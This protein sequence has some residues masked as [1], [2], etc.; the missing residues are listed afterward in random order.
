M[1]N[2][3]IIIL[4]TFVAIFVIFVVTVAVCSAQTSAQP[5]TSGQPLVAKISAPVTVIEKDIKYDVSTIDFGY[6]F[7]LKVFLQSN[8]SEQSMDK[9][10]K[11]KL[12]DN[13]LIEKAFDEC[14]KRNCQVIEIR[15]VEKDVEKITTGM[16]NF[17]RK[18]QVGIYVPL[19][20][21]TPN[22]LPANESRAK[23]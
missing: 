4:L 14:E 22:K 17:G 18:V 12:W 9:L 23:Q 1:K 16:S 6:K 2:R 20:K 19:P 3:S 8:F 7:S 11:T 21:P 5:L 15:I 10:L 13:D